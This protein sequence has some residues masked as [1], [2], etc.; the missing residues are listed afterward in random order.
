MACPP[1]YAPGLVAAMARRLMGL[2][3]YNSQLHIIY[4]A[5]DVLFKALQVMMPTYLG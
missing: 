4:L 3:D 2:P 5:N 1:A